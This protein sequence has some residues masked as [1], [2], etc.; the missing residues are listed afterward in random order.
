MRRRW[1]WVF[2]ASAAAAVLASA[3]CS[4]GG[5]GAQKSVASSASAAA[6]A[7]GASAAATKSAAGGSSWAAAGLPD[8]VSQVVGDQVVKTAELR[9]DLRRGTYASAFSDVATIA[10]SAGG[11][12]ASS[13]TADDDG[14]HAASMVVRVPAA[15]FDDARRALAKLGTVRSESLKGDDVGAQIADIDARVRNLTA[16]AEALRALMQRATSVAD[17]MAVQQQLFAVQQQIEQLT[18]Q[19][20]RLADQVRLSTIT[21]SIAEPGAV[22]A[23][24]GRLASSFGKAWRGAESVLAA[25]VVATGY[26]VPL[27]LLVALALGGWRLA[28]RRDRVSPVVT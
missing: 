23:G 2:T 15:A 3:G 1:R 9:I 8:A 5:A 4:G 16:Q 12:V 22:P 18:A 24:E 27:A 13:T 19:N 10:S 28:R 26:L 7:S 11:F 25:V 17:T 6:R 20:A 14:A 21:V